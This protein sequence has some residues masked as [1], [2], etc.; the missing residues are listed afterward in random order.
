MREQRVE[1]A[2]DPDGF[3]V[4][5]PVSE[6]GETLGVLELLLPASPDLSTIEYV[7]SAAHALAYV[8]IADRRHSDMYELAQRSTDLSLEAEI[9][10]RLL[11]PSYTCQ[12]PQ[13]ELPRHRASV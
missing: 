7:A 13:R 4:Y 12:G 3:R 10:R 1:L 9:Q 8:V 5:A 6:R 11:P 2:L